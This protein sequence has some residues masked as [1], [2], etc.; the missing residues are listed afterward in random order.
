MWSGVE[1]VSFHLHASEIRGRGR[2]YL[3]FSHSSLDCFRKSMFSRIA[4]H[5][6]IFCTEVKSEAKTADS[7]VTAIKAATANETSNLQDTIVEVVRK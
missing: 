2:V 4:T 3:C 5:K 6:S 7:P 1:D